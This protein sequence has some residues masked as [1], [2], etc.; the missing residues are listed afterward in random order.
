MDTK[1]ILGELDK[2]SMSVNTIKE[3]LGTPV[4]IVIP[5]LPTHT[6]NN[7]TN[8]LVINKFA[9]AFGN[10]FY[11]KVLA[12]AGLADIA[13]SRDAIYSGLPVESL[14]LTDSEKSQLIAQ[15]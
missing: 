4:P 13:N 14:S 1:L 12:K 6:M 9:A 8:Q 15:L 11:W 7:L 3:A 5:P 10:N 2:I